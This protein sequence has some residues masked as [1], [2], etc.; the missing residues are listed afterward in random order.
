MRN[1]QGG[2]LLQVA[3][4]LRVKCAIRIKLYD[5][6][7]YLRSWTNLNLDII[8]VEGINALL[9]YSQIKTSDLIG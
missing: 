8:Q 4:E 1:V 3:R 7:S 2:K 9:L 5:I 6:Y